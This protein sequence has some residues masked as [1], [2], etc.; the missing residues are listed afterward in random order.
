MT[1]GSMKEGKVPLPEATG[2]LKEPEGSML[3]R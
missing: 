1:E 3:T 2:W